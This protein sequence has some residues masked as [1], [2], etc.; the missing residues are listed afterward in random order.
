MGSRLT[1]PKSGVEWSSSS[2][3]GSFGEALAAGAGAAG[4]ADG[5]VGARCLC[6]MAASA[7]LCSCMPRIETRPIEGYQAHHLGTSYLLSS[8]MHKELPVI[9]F[10]FGGS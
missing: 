6:V 4:G 1:W 10:I 5:R 7:V 3:G 2:L 8:I 9:V